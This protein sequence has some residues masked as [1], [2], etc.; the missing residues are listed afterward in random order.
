MAKSIDVALAAEELERNERQQVREAEIRDRAR[1][2]AQAATAGN[3]D[4]N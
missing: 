2:A 3:N 1:R 4:R